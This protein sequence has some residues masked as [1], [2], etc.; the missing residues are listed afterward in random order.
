MER[1]DTSLDAVVEGYTAVF[2]NK[3]PRETRDDPSD[4]IHFPAFG[5]AGVELTQHDPEFQARLKELDEALPFE[6][7]GYKVNRMLRI[8]QKNKLE[9]MDSTY[10]YSFILPED[11]IPDLRDVVT[12]DYN[13]YDL[14]YRQVQSNV[15]PRYSIIP[16]IANMYHERFG[17]R[18]EVY[19]LGCSR[20]HGLN[21]LSR[22]EEFP[23]DTVD[24]LGKLPYEFPMYWERGK[25]ENMADY[26]H[27]EMTDRLNLHYV[28]RKIELAYAMGIDR[29]SLKD[30]GNK[31]WVLACSRYPREYSE[32]TWLHRFD[33]LEKQSDDVKFAQA[34]CTVRDEVQ[35]VTD[36]RK[37]QM[38]VLST[39]MYQM[40]S[41]QRQQALEIAQDLLVD[42]GIIVLHDAVD[43]GKH[44]PNVLHFAEENFSPRRPFGYK[45]LIFDKA[46]PKLGFQ[47]FFRWRDGRCKVMIPNLGNKVVR[48]ALVS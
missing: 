27:D 48:A 18:V 47:E 37:A 13:Y 11:F 4:D 31:L 29:E 24:V 26:K 39:V 42:D 35:D 10:P 8:I 43:A 23:F 21:R 6:R 41:E 25:D 40:T 20:N 32:P 5:G 3:I 17:G 22:I 12:N 34:D 46:N 14:Y 7:R 45:T 33:E 2:K 38:V 30:G 36:S 1:L 19:D 44:R 15:D 16:I 9:R 28:R